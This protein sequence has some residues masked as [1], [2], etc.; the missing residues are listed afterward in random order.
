MASDPR[1]GEGLDIGLD[2]MIR[3]DPGYRIALRVEAFA[4][5][6]ALEM[7]LRTDH[8]VTWWRSL[9]YFPWTQGGHG[10]GPEIRVEATEPVLEARQFLFAPA[11]TVTGVFELWKGGWGGFGVFAGALPVNAWA[12]RGRRLVFTWHQ[13]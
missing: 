3:D 11:L 7:V 5:D 4:D 6:G 8:P 2:A 13:D 10:S 9:S 1:S 12:N